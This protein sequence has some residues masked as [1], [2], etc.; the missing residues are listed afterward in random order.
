MDGTVIPD[1][2]T[3]TYDKWLFNPDWQTKTNHKW[4]VAMDWQT[5]TY[6][7]GLV[8]PDLFLGLLLY[9]WLLSDPWLVPPAWQTGR[10][11]S[12]FCSTSTQRP[13]HMWNLVLVQP[14]ARF[15]HVS[16]HAVIPAPHSEPKQIINFL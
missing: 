11:L 3:G 12:H 1:W 8:L 7:M 10:L 9:S 15:T 13:S 14:Q 4:L 5:D 6:D 2:Q 16:P